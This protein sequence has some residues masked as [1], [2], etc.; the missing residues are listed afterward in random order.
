MLPPEP[1]PVEPR[2]SET[3][4][5]DARAVPV[6]RCGD[7]AETWCC[8]LSKARLKRVWA[9]LHEL[10]VVAAAIEK[11]SRGL[12]AELTLRVMSMWRNERCSRFHG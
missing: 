10:G 7:G 2:T 5:E 12:V 1:G 11:S 8:L 3:F 9:P 6:A 4:A